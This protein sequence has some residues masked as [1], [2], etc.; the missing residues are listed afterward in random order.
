[1]SGL[2]ADV[3]KLAQGPDQF[4]LLGGRGRWRGNAPRAQATVDALVARVRAW[5]RERDGSVHFDADGR[6]VVVIG[7]RAITF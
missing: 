2:K 4:R 1:M 7:S 3:F 5:A 6:L